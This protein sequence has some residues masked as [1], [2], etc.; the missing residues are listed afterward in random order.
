MVLRFTLLFFLFSAALTTGFSQELKT[1]NVFFITLDGLRWEEL[2]GGADD[3]LIRDTRFVKDTSLLLEKYWAPN[4]IMRRQKLMPWFW[5][6]VAE[7]GQLLGNRQLG[8]NANLTNLMWFSYPGY[9]ELL[10]GYSDP[11]IN[12]NAKIPNSNVT[13]LEWLH[14][15]EDF[16]GKVAAFG[17]W[18]VFPF[19]INEERSR[20][21]VNAGF[22]NATGEP[23]SEREQFLNQLQSQIPSPWN[24]VRLDAFTHHFALEYIKKK[25]PR[26]VYVSY[27]ETD[28]FAHDSRYD[29]YLDATYRTDAFIRDLWEFCQGDSAYANQTTFVICTDHGRGDRPKSEWT[30]HGKGIRG[31]NEVWMAFLGP[32]TPPLGERNDKLQIWQNQVAKTVAAFLGQDYN[33]SAESVGPLIPGVIR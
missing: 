18:D 16:Q 30:S 1:K 10:V 32:D 21:P 27:G 24:S 6:T 3:S 11:N 23:L 14:Q 20:I 33:P 17:S 31:S 5:G 22:E 7:H 9:N 29:H 15:K 2:F 28:D 19:I 4:S 25:H 13:V 12:S 8:N 26:V